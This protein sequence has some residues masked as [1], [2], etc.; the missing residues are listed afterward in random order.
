MVLGCLTILR[1]NAP[2]REK[3]NEQLLF[4][5]ALNLAYKFFYKNSNKKIKY[6]CLENAWNL[7]R[8]FI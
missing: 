1:I 6:S 8:V 4:E 7:T 3:L 2:Y 5:N